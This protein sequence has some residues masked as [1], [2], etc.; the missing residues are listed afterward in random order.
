[1]TTFGALYKPSGC[2]Y[3]LFIY[4]TI[5]LTNLRGKAKL[6]TL[7]DGTTLRCELTGLFTD[8]TVFAELR[9]L[10]SDTVL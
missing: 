2:V 5:D 3:C 1:M 6:V 8:V 4:F 7:E 9:C 10:L